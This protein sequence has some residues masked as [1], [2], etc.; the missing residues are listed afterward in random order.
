MSTKK[1][2]A[3]RKMGN[4]TLGRE[5]RNHLKERIN[6]VREWDLPKPKDTA[7]VAKARA[8]VE[9][10]DAKNR[11]GNAKAR[12]E[13]DRAKSLA[14][15]ELLRTDS[16]EEGLRVVQKFEALAKRKGWLDD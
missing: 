10:F 8:F 9:A 7:A 13:V 2:A 1:T 6:Q 11:S 16:F 5:R 12:R 3:P 14:H 4:D 15:G